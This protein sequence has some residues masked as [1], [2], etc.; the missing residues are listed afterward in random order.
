MASKRYEFRTKNEKLQSLLD[1]ANSK[2]KL[3]EDIL[4]DY[5]NG[6][7]LRK[8]DYKKSQ[9]HA[10]AKLR[11]DIAQA[12][13]YEVDA[14]IAMIRELNYSPDR[15]AEI[16]NTGESILNASTNELIQP[17]NS[18]RCT[19]CGKIIEAKAY[20]FESIDEYERHIKEA[21]NRQLYQTERSKFNEWLQ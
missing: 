15:V 10:D 5:S 9:K 1:N 12:I 20:Q 14:K 21:H 3:I 13:K 18:L 7:L 11:K 16:M 19:S 6:E 8:V 2:S 17:D 4:T